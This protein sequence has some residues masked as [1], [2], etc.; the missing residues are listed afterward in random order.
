[1]HL[2]SFIKTRD[3]AHPPLLLSQRD[4]HSC[5][6]HLAPSPLSLGRQHAATAGCSGSG[7]PK[8]GGNGKKRRATGADRGFQPEFPNEERTKILSSRDWREPGVIT[9]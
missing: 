9:T 1:M 4:C 2:I 6:Y 3:F 7:K 8:T 5:S